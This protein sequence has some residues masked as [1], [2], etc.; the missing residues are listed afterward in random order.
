MVLLEK[1][2]GVLAAGVREGRKTFA[3]TL[4]YIYMTT[5]ANFGK[6]R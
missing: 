3:N 5:S 4:K 2:L 1:D 6:Q